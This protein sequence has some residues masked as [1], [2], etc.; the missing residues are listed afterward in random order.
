MNTKQS[1]V[2]SLVFV[3]TLGAAASAT[4][5]EAGRSRESIQA[6]VRAQTPS[7]QFCYEQLLLQQPES[8]GKLELHFTIAAGGVVDEV[9]IEKSEFASSFD[10]C[11]LEAAAKWRFEAIE[12]GIT[13]VR[14]PFIFR[15]D[16]APKGALA[17]AVIKE[18]IGEHKDEL[19]T[20]YEQALLLDPGLEGKLIARFTID[21]QGAVSQL[22]IE[23]SEGVSNP[24]ATACIFDVFAALRFPAPD[25]GVVEVSYPLLFSSGGTR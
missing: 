17:A 2:V 14:Y 19:K 13:Q 7:I 10:A 24:E 20:C 5:Q 25:G 18:T 22:S 1:T 21:A 9:R 4:A 15:P 12:D 16:E 8:A 6:S 11:V 3:L 23:P